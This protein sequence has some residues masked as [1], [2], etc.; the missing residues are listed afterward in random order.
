[1]HHAHNFQSQKIL[2]DIKKNTGFP[3]Q[4]LS[5]FVFYFLVFVSLDNNNVLFWLLIGVFKLFILYW[6]IAN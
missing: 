5:K 2:Y 3:P 1:M 4:L 6:G